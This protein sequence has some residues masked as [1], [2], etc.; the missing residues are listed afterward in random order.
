MEPSYY[1]VVDFNKHLRGLQLRKR[2]TD[3]G[4]SN[5]LPSSTPSSLRTPG[6]HRA[7]FTGGYSNPPGSHYT[8]SVYG[9]STAERALE[10]V[11]RA[12]LDET[13]FKPLR[14]GM[15]YTS[16]K[17]QFAQEC[18]F[19]QVYRVIDPGFDP[20]EMTDEIDI[21]L[22]DRQH[23]FMWLVLIDALRSTVAQLILQ[24]HIGKST[25]RT[26]FFAFEVKE[27]GNVNQTYA[28]AQLSR[29][30]GETAL[31]RFTGTS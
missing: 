2:M 29:E 21:E 23:S 9:K 3:R 16:W 18:R 15:N 27:M 14:D 4:G 7:S 5:M 20:E 31:D 6:S 26:A 17:E 10:S 8:S 12:P 19:Q 25:A 24:D 11:L 13:K 1:H 30:L 28:I 22:Y